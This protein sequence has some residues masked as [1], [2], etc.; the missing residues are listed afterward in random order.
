VYVFSHNDPL[1]N[2]IFIKESDDDLLT[3]KLIDFEFSSY[4]LEM[5]DL[6]AHYCEL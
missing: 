1:L 3:I 2:N 5:F 6:A 4:N